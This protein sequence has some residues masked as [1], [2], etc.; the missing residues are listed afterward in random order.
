MVEG[1]AEPGFRK[2]REVFEASFDGDAADMRVELGAAV[3]VYLDGRPVVDL[4]GGWLDD[5]RQRT[6]SEDS[7]VCVQS[8]GKGVLATCAHVLVERGLL[9]LDRPVADY[10]PEFAQSG[11]GELP[12]RWALSHSLGLP[13][14]ERPTRGIGYEWEA[15][16]AALAA[17]RPD[18]IPG[19]QLSY[20]P[21]TFGYVVGELIR[22]ITGDSVDAFL[23]AEVTNRWRVDFQFGA[24]SDDAART[25]TFTRMRHADNLD[26]NRAIEPQAYA[27]VRVRSLDVLDLDEDYNSPKWRGSCIPAANGHTNARALGRLYGGLAAAG[28]LDG[29]RLMLPETIAA[30][31]QRQW[32][33][34]HL[35]IP[36]TAN[37]ALGYI[38]NSPSFPAGPNPESFGHAGFGGAF[39]FADPSIGLGFG[40]T[41][42]KLWLGEELNTGERCDRLVRTLFECLGAA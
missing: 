27:D 13:A 35:L 36:M 24:S 38:L 21:Y 30:A 17:S 28:E 8:V 16:T 42:N 18:L 39:G 12:V 10:W 2:L 6:W 40:Y 19:K 23:A 7:I 25:A 29:V 9:E 4:W 5:T 34:R 15:A 22:R 3:S 11:K 41:P 33:G 14:W 31:C 32:G 37:M 26:A 20:H 1:Y